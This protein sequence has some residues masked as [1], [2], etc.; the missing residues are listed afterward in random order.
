MGIPDGLFRRNPCGDNSGG[1]RR[2]GRSGPLCSSPD[3]LAANRS[4]RIHQGAVLPFG[5]K[6][7]KFGCRGAI[8][9]G[10]D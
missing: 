7:A 3:A 6:K 1:I 10:H 8:E 4:H 5:S 9:L 2:L